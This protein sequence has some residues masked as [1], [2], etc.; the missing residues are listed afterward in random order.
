MTQQGNTIRVSYH[1]SLFSRYSFFLSPSSGCLVQ[2]FSLFLLKCS[3]P[4]VEPSSCGSQW[5][6]KGG[7]FISSSMSWL[8]KVSDGRGVEPQTGRALWLTD[9]Y[10]WKWIGSTLC[11]WGHTHT[12]SSP[13]IPTWERGERSATVAMGLATRESCICLTQM[14]HVPVTWIFAWN[15]AFRLLY[16]VFPLCI[17]CPLMW[18]EQCSGGIYLPISDS[19]DSRK[20]QLRSLLA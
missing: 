11:H 14:S 16:F 15:K 18:T 8:F 6:E 4:P 2:S 20:N 1:L 13:A 7:M 9:K 17:T 5:P 12:D 10:R 3:L 19:D